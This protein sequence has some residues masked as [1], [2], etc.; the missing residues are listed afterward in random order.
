MD[1][2]E[3]LLV[4]G[5]VLGSSGATAL[6][7]EYMQYRARQKEEARRY[8]SK[9]LLSRDFLEY[10]GAFSVV[11]YLLHS[12]IDLVGDGSVEIFDPSSKNVP[13]RLKITRSRQL[14]RIIGRVMSEHKRRNIE[15]LRSGR[16]ALWPPELLP[17]IMKA[18]DS[19][20][21]VLNNES[22]SIDQICGVV[23][24]LVDLEDEVRDIFGLK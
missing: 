17:H 2:N 24:T 13:R 12:M 15:I 8:L 4:I 6:V 10:M 19:I 21:L 23:K 14:N 3:I 1:L 22:L 7:F 20:E 9:F 16:F 11:V 5:S 18:E